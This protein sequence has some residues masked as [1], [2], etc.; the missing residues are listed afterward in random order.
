VKKR[1]AFPSR[2]RWSNGTRWRA[3]RRCW[4][5]TGRGR[6]RAGRSATCRRRTFSRS[7]VC[8]V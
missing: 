1:L 5:L 6:K 8:R 7:W 4:C 2:K 3:I